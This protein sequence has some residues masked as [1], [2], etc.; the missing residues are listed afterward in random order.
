MP[1]SKKGEPTNIDNYSGIGLPS[2]PGKVFAIPLKIRLQ[3]W[4]KAMLMEGN[5]VFER[6]DLATMQLSA[7]M[8]YASSQLGQAMRYMLASLTLAKP[9]TLLTCL[10]PRSF[11]H[12]WGSPPKMLQLIKDLH[13]NTTCAMPADKD[14][15]GK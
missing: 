12:P 11:S 1:F 13:D 9:M 5:L 7:S 10:L 15:Q 4:A 8:G 3:R 2:L 6:A 14:K